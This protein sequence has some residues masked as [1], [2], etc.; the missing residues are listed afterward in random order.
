MPEP[1]TR[2]KFRKWSDGQVIAFFFEDETA[3]LS[4]GYCCGSYQHIG[5]HS[6][7]NLELMER[8]KSASPEEYASLKAELEGEPF[9]YRLE[10]V[11]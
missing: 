3:K 7:A 10:V 8:L 1:I 9:N 11:E 2:V 4:R 5:Q 6:E